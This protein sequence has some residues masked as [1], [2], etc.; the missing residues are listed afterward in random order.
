M[1]LKTTNYEV[2]K[3]GI[4]IPEAYAV[5]DFSLEGNSCLVTVK[6]QTSR[7]NAKNLEPLE[8][9]HTH[10]VIDR[11]KNPFEEVYNK[12]KGQEIVERENLVTGEK[13]TITVS[14]IL[15][16]WEDDIIEAE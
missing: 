9:I 3:L 15:Y 12:L 6:I 8:T 7:E 11:N 10:F 13:E 1:G 14:G 4:T 2:K 16:G 5:A